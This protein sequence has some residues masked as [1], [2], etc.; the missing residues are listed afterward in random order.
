M[1]TENN[2]TMYW[3]WLREVLRLTDWFAKPSTVKFISI[4]NASE[5]R[6]LMIKILQCVGVMQNN[7]NECNVYTYF[8][9]DWITLAEVNVADMVLTKKKFFFYFIWTGKL[10]IDC[11]PYL[12]RY[13]QNSPLNLAFMNGISD[14]QCSK[15]PLEPCLDGYKRKQ[16]LFE[17][18]FS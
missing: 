9:I 7:L 1:L 3:K 13:Q 12:P 6:K 4:Q 17:D 2:F 14:G 16:S 5:G 15:Q 11:L 8:K 10:L 18:S